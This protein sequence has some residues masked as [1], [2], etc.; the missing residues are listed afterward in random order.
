MKITKEEFKKLSN[1]AKLKHIQ[2]LHPWY[3]RETIFDLLTS[4]SME[5]MDFKLLG[6][7]A[8]VHINTQ[9]CKE[10]MDI[11]DMFPEEYKDAIWYYR[12]AYAHTE[13]SKEYGNNF[14]EEVRSA[15]EKLE[16]AVKIS[17]DEE[18]TRWCLYLVEVSE[19]EGILKEKKDKYTLLSRK[20][21]EYINSKNKKI[22]ETIQMAKTQ[23]KKIYKKNY[24]R[25]Y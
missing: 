22:E 2:N 6:E 20:Y 23:K 25:G 1:E 13:L 8:R 5:E 9:K 10:G 19:L 17:N 18:V 3:D 11:L 12:Y 21:F 24:C 14:E 4:V 7:L 15:F 16:T